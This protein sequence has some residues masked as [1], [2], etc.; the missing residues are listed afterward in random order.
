MASEPVAGF[1]CRSNGDNTTGPV[2]GPDRSRRYQSESESDVCTS[3]KGSARL[4]SRDENERAAALEE[5]RQGV[6]TSLAAPDRTGSARLSKVTLLYLLRLSRSCPLREVREGATELLRAAQVIPRKR[7][8]S[9]RHNLCIGAET[10]NNST[11]VGLIFHQ[12][13]CWNCVLYLPLFLL[14]K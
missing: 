13:K 10:Q 12:D 11:L 6:L 2:S 5:L 8:Q 14:I 7:F 1:T 4:C 9:V 3:V